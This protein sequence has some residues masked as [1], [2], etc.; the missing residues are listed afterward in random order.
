MDNTV[1]LCV[2]LACVST[3]V[4]GNAFK[5]KPCTGADEKGVASTIK[6]EP[7]DTFPCKFQKGE[8]AHINITFTAEE[9]S[10]KLDAEVYGIILGIPIHYP[11]PDADGCSAKSGVSC[12]IKKGQTYTYT[13][14]FPLL[15]I[16]P[17][18]NLIVKWKLNTDTKNAVC[19]T[20]PMSI[21]DKAV[22][23]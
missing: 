23:G 8:T 22:V 15:D 2:V 6:V 1:V 18:I 19:F 10:N 21:V 20:F 17:S 14:S 11:L 7:C 5:W 3:C 4:S 16:Y 12:P 9:D 13:G